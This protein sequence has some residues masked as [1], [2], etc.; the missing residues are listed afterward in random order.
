MQVYS[1][2]FLLYFIS[3][4]YFFVTK[5]N[6]TGV[7]NIKRPATEQISTLRPVP[8]TSKPFCHK[9]GCATSPIALVVNENIFT[10]IIWRVNFPVYIVSPS[11]CSSAAG[12]G[13]WVSVALLFWVVAIERDRCGGKNAPSLRFVFEIFSVFKWILELGKCVAAAAAFGP[14]DKYHRKL[15]LDFKPCE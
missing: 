9:T 4:T 15:R 7:T 10:R 2:V 1:S 6:R 8:L 14:V 3:I 5:C 12:G 13:G 11:G